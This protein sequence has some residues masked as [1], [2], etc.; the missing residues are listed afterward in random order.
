MVKGCEKRIVYLKNTGSPMFDEAYFVINEKYAARVE[1]ASG[2]VISEAHRLIEESIKKEGG[3]T[4]RERISSYLGA[5]LKK[6]GVSFLLGALFC[7]VIMLLI[8]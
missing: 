6:W 1:G 5:A 8:I 2:S 3:R 4:R 7:A